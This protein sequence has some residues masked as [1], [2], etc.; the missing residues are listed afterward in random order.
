VST[1]YIILKRTPKGHIS[2]ALTE[3]YEK[4]EAE[5]I[6]AHL[7]RGAKML[8]VHNSYML[9]AVEVPA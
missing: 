9:A 3:I 8:D 1:G 4:D 6:I 2:A 5:E 7:V